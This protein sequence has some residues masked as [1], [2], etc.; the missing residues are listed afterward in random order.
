[1]RPESRVTIFRLLVYFNE[2]VFNYI[3]GISLLLHLGKCDD[4]QN[5]DSHN[6]DCHN[7]DGIKM[8]EG[9]HECWGILTLAC[10]YAPAVIWLCFV[11]RFRT[12]PY[13]VTFVAKCLTRF[14]LWPVIMPLHL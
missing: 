3:V 6:D 14:L 4:S 10:T 5:D 11:F 12:K 13:S 1:M 2:V 7:D 8:Y 9:S